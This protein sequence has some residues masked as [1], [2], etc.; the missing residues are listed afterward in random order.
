MSNFEVVKPMIRV[1]Y[2]K[3]VRTFAQVHILHHILSLALFLA[4][5]AHATVIKKL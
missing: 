5:T 4:L 1:F 3:R 2:A